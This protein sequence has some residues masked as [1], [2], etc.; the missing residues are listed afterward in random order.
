MTPYE[1][2]LRESQERMLLVAED[3]RER[4]VLDVFEKWGL[5][6][7]VV[8]EVTEGGLLRV[9]DRDKLAAEIPAH[10]LAE[11][12]PVYRRPIAQPSLRKET[13]GDWF[14]FLAGGPNLP[15]KFAR[16]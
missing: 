13:A 10:P 9:R 16:L 11:E 14:P 4:E 2:I 6:A 15:P 8:G 12:G 5:D 7:V 3:G 1:M